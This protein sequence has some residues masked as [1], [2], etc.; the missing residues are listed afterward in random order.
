MDSTPE[1][2]VLKDPVGPTARRKILPVLVTGGL[3]ALAG[4]WWFGAEKN[5]SHP[6][7]SPLVGHEA[8]NTNEVLPMPAALP[9][10]PAPDRA[11]DLAD[12]LK[13]GLRSPSATDR[14]HAFAV[15]L[16]RLLTLDADAAT[17]LA[18]AW[19]PGALREELMRQ[20]ITRWAA[21]DL[22]RT[23]TWL[24]GLRDEADRRNAAQA[25][26][27]QVGQS[28]P[29]GA[30]ELAELLRVGSDDGSLFHYA[31]L[32][33]EEN[34]QA[35]VAWAVQHKPGQL[36]DQL[37]TRVAWVRAQSDP[38]EAATLVLQHLDAGPVRDQ[39]IAGVVRHWAVRDQVAAEAWVSAFPPGAAKDLALKELAT[40]RKLR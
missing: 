12:A 19:E 37:L 38:V 2:R 4:L 20:L 25:V 16:P 30:L 7:A 14:D 10:S 9:E 27:D 23:L 32:W 29:I 18:L 34:P 24:T 5:R 36:R 13:R 15:L 3:L 17:R 35:A 6:P 8:A 33:T 11:V 28:D 21:I 31:Q 39:A 1:K 26:T 22:G 40:A